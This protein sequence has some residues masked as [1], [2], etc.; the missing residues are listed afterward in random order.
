MCEGVCHQEVAEF[1]VNAW[2][3]NGQTRKKGKPQTCNHQNE[4]ETAEKSPARERQDEVANRTA[5][6]PGRFSEEELQKQ[7]NAAGN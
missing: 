5:D 6:S 1:V 2:S 7:Q 4:Q 3:G